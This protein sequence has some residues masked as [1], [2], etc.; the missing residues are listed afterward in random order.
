[1]DVEAN[2]WGDVEKLAADPNAKAH[3]GPAGRVTVAIEAETAAYARYLAF[4]I[5]NQTP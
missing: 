1:M 5:G 4:H 3:H 2:N